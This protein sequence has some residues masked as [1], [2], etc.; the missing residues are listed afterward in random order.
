MSC[1]TL[2]IYTL[3]QHIAFKELYP[4]CPKNVYQVFGQPDGVNAM[5]E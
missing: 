3:R 1:E 4:Y 2:N 5:C